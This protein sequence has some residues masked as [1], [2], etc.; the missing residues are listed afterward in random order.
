MPNEIN[1]TW[2]E[3]V[4]QFRPLLN[5]MEP[6][7]FDGNKYHMFQPYG[8]QLEFVKTFID[9]D[10]VWSFLDVTDGQ[11]IYAG[12][13]ESDCNGYYITEEPF[14]KN[15]FY[16]VNFLGIDEGEDPYV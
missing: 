8:E 10:R 3:W 4:E 12:Y 9:Q 6:D 7:G 16:Q 14:D 11:G 5:Q 13:K 1:M 15:M 2:D